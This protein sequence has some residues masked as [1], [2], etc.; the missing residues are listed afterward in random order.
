MERYPE[1][2]VA[3]LGALRRARA[4]FHSWLYRVTSEREIIAK[5]IDRWNEVLGGAPGRGVAPGVGAKRD[6]AALV[7]RYPEFRALF[8]Y[9]VA[10]ERRIGIR[11][12]LALAD[13]CWRPLESLYIVTPSIGPGLFIQHGF[14]TIIAAKSLGENCWVNQ[15]V[16]I[17]FSSVDDCP[18]LGNNVS[19]KAGAIVIGDIT[20]GDGAV[21]GA[22]AV[23]VKDV[24]PGSTVVGVPARPIER[25]AANADGARGVSSADGSRDA[26]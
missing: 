26:R 15:Q 20:I 5:D 18:T 12:L 24:P 4:C 8:H 7:A 6:I 9:R 22:G 14:S 23:V 21:V 25:G 10:R 3:A 17:G 19:V 2:S 13:R 16:T 11:A 1:S